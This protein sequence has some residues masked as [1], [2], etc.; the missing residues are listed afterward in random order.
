MQNGLNAL[1]LASKEGHVDVMRELLR[2]GAPVNGTTKVRCVVNVVESL[3]MIVPC[4][5]IN[6]VLQ[7]VL[8]FLILRKKF[9]PLTGFRPPEN[10]FRW[11][12]SHW[13]T[14]ALQ[15]ISSRW[16]I[17]VTELSVIPNVFDLFLGIRKSILLKSC[18]FLWPSSQHILLYWILLSSSPSW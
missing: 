13:E 2:R 15:N 3:L 10:H 12:S 14:L 4:I 16:K 8:A 11:C 9:E 7:I 6:A 17:L 1:H 5:T 18:G